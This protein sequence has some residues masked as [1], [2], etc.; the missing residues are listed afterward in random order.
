MYKNIFVLLICLA[1]A[2]CSTVPLPDQPLKK[3]AGKVYE[4]RQ[5]QLLAW[6]VGPPFWA[7]VPSV[8]E[9]S[10][11]TMR[12]PAELLNWLLIPGLV[13]G[14]AMGLFSQSPLISK[15]CFK[16]A[17]VSGLALI[18]CWCI[19]L[20][21]AKVLVLVPVLLAVLTISYYLAKKKG[22]LFREEATCSQPL[23]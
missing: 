23:H 17:G 19:I 8:W 13:L 12:K 16:M 11:A 7:E 20:A 1:I 4:A 15:R 18:G 10:L 14:V 9:K 22:L 2:S 6:P 5:K 3:K 21:T